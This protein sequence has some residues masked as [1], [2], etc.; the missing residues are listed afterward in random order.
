M[1]ALETLAYFIK[2]ISLGLRLAIN[3]TTGHVLVKTLVGFIW[4]AYLKGSSIIILAL[5]LF[6]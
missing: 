3:L 5:P 4:T 2:V 6:L 1:I